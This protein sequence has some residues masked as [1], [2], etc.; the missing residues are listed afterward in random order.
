VHK[1]QVDQPLEEMLVKEV[2]KVEVNKSKVKKKKKV[3]LM[4]KVV[5]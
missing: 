3:E 2:H 4:E 1:A 5:S